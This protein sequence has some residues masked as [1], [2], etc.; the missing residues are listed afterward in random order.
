MTKIHL[1][2]LLTICFGMNVLAQV[3][4]SHG[5]SMGKGPNGIIFEEDFN[6][7]TVL[8]NGWTVYT[9]DSWDMILP[10]NDEV[11]FFKQ[12]TGVKTMILSTPLVDL[13]N[14]SQLT[15]RFRSGKVISTLKV[16]LMS[17]PANPATFQLLTQFQA[18]TNMILYT[19]PLGTATGSSYVAFNW[20]G[21]YFKAAY[22]DDVIIYD[23]GLQNNVPSNV[24]SALLTPAPNGVSSGTLSWVNPSNE[25]DGDP[26]TDLDSVTVKL[27]GSYYATVL[28]PVIG[29]GQ[30]LPVTVPQPGM[31]TATLT[32]Y[33]TAGAG[34]PNTTTEVWVGLDMPAE[35]TGVILTQAGNEATLKWSPPKVGMHGGYFN[36]VVTQYLVWR[37]DNWETYVPGTDSSIVMNVTD[38]GTFNYR[39]IPENPSGSGP[40]GVSN[41]GVF[42]TGNYLLW[43]DFWVSVPAHLWSVQGESFYNW[44]LGNSNLA[45]GDAPELLFQSTSPYFNSYSRM[46]SPSLNT[47]GKS[48]VTLEFRHQHTAYGAYHL[49]IETSSDDGQTWQTGLLIQ[50]TAAQPA[51][52]KTVVLTTSDVGSAN[53]RFAFT[54][55]GFEG[56]LETFSIDNVR[57]SPTV[58]IDV[59][60]NAL[61][62]PSLIHPAD[63]VVPEAIVQNLGITDAP[64]K[65]YCTIRNTAG[66]LYSDSVTALIQTGKS[67]TVSF[68]SVVMP[69]GELSA[70]VIVRCLSDGNPLNDTVRNDFVS[71]QTYQRSMV[72][73]EDATGTW[74]TY[75]PGASMGIADLM[76][77]GFAVAAISYHGGDSYQTPESR[78]RINYYPAI[79][80]F[81][82]VMF[83]GVLSYVGGT[84]STSMYS[85]YLPLVQQRLDRATPV[86]VSLGSATISS[87]VLT[88][89]VGLESLS[90]VRNNNLV[91]HAVLTESKIQQ[92][93]QDQTELN[94]VERVMYA[95]STGTSVDLS[96]KAESLTVQMPVNPSWVQNNL[97]LVVFVQDKVT[98]EI[99]NADIK[100]PVTGMPDN[101]SA[102]LRLYPN[103]ASQFVT[104]PVLKDATV[105]V[106]NLA[107]VMVFSGERIS[108]AY[109][110][111]VVNLDPG[112]YLVKVSDRGVEYSTKIQVIH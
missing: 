32:P 52:T 36:G 34:V 65:A 105:K 79:T 22:L 10:Q 69:E 87:N 110:L 49:K 96:D 38:P 61:L 56:N 54:F 33:N 48:A 67:D 45:G 58:G 19:V 28:N 47:S 76:S 9:Q 5:S 25:A 13:T 55:E 81:P 84:H 39:V 11:L 2:I 15:F 44:W 103:P 111:G 68:N 73:L 75:C 60:A 107:G 93:W 14:A 26:L 72:L 92:A 100:Q 101:G 18:D 112:L 74:C 70:S 66:I 62:L 86:K 30:S 21:T 43:E 4:G 94:E 89:Q 77:H 71:Y 51:E 31:Y 83:D 98:R 42:L 109:R 99:F 41:T 64:Y 91:V 24:N 6:G 102:L 63:V 57:L 78:A 8:P 46:V 12:S 106:Y 88:A 29:V 37:A 50:I 90:P 7:L 3:T 1:V 53:F 20:V 16:G 108:G 35:P 80:G 95:D 85:N 27:N 82:T 40:A 104:F 23:D 17:D 97:Q 59:A